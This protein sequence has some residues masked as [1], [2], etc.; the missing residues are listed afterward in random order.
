MKSPDINT[1]P[2]PN[3]PPDHLFN[4][5]TM[6]NTIPVLYVYSNEKYNSKNDIPHNTKKVYRKTIQKLDNRSFKYY[7]NEIKAFY[8]A[9]YKY[10]L[11]NKNVIVFGLTGCNCDAISIWN[12]AKKVYVVDY[13]KPVC[14]HEK[15]EVLTLSEIGEVGGKADAAFAYSSF[16]HDGLGRYGDPLD[17]YGDLRAMEETHSLLVGGGILFLGVPLGLDTLVWNLHR[18]YGKLRL[19]LLLK[20]WQCLDVYN[21][22]TG[23]SAFY[24][25]D[26]PPLDAI[27]CILVL[28]KIN[29]PY[30]NDLT[31]SDKN[32]LDTFD[33]PFTT[34]SPKILH[35]INRI[36][37]DYKHNQPSISNNNV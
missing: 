8:D 9:L 22:Y 37:L 24:P 15:V 36:I 5:F 31:L 7:G 1:P 14:E 34:Y 25:F 35:R 19:P 26:L 2:P 10:P 21:T 18:I 13:N 30:P 3:I 6:N 17:Q 29:E 12:N 33:Y 23:K 11:N 16:E 20:G 27:Q 4:D 28:R 32:I